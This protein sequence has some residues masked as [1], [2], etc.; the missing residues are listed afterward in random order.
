MNK[1]QKNKKHSNIINQDFYILNFGKKRF[2]STDL[3]SRDMQY[4]NAA[5][6]KA[7]RA[8]LGW[9]QEDLAEK[10]G[11]SPNTI[12][13]LEMGFISRGKTLSIIREA[14]EK[15]GLEFLEPAGIRPRLDDI[16]VYDGPDS[17]KVLLKDMVQTA[18]EVDGGII[19]LAKT[20]T[21]LAK[22]LGA[23][24]PKDLECLQYVETRCMLFDATEAP[25]DMS[26]IQFRMAPDNISPA[27]Y[28]VYGDKH[29]LITQE[30]GFNFRFVVFTL[31]IQA[32]SY[33]T[34]FQTVWKNAEL[35]ANTT[36]RQRV[37]A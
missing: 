31:P 6:I 24:C 37:C 10:T 27:S 23:T 21:L 34:H 13:N 7:G 8:Y 30:S 11:L 5:H 35:L 25:F 26:R 36:T 17:C 4:I 16:K 18:K 29:V 12:R 15:G 20:P 2:F 19:I 9:S 14:M 3:L 28:F 32:H 22:Y 1:K 33:R